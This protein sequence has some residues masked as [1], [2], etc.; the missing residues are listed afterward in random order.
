MYRKPN[1]RRKQ[2]GKLGRNLHHI[3]PKSR[4]GLA[5]RNNLLLIDI[6]KHEAWHKLFGLH[7]IQEVVEILER[8]DRAKRHQKGE[9][10]RVA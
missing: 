5:T 7:T 6:E 4:G 2:F 1:R 10:Y 8:I 9:L 3:L